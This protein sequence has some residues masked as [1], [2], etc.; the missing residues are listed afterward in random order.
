MSR[1][2]LNL[3]YLEGIEVHVIQAGGQGGRVTN[4]SHKKNLNLG[5]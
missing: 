1:K 5:Y 3:E 4:M 2:N